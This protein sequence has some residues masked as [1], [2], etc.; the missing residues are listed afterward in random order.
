M[1]P[2]IICREYDETRI[3]MPDTDSKTRFTSCRQFSFLFNITENI[4]FSAFKNGN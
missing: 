1:S 4:V 2:I 3:E